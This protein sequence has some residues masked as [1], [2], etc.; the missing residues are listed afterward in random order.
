MAVFEKDNYDY[1]GAG[2]LICDEWLLTTKSVITDPTTNQ[3]FL[4][5][6]VCGKY[7]NLKPKQEMKKMKNKNLSSVQS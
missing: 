6:R 2:T 5:D 3:T 4:P 1:L 7:S